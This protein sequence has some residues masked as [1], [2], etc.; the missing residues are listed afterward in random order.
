MENIRKEM[1]NLIREKLRAIILNET[2][3]NIKLTNKKDVGVVIKMSIDRKLDFRPP[4]EQSIQK[5]W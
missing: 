2:Y 3:S 5:K 4:E 1:Q